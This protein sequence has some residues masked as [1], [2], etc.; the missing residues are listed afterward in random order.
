M[1]NTAF[2]HMLGYESLDDL[3]PATLKNLCFDP[4]QAIDFINTI[5]QDGTKGID[6]RLKR[7]DGSLLWGF[8]T[9]RPG[10]D[11][12][13]QATYFDCTIED[14]TDRRQA[15]K[16]REAMYLISQAA[17]TA[18]NLEDLLKLVHKII[19]DLMPANNF[20]LALFDAEHNTVSFPYY[21]DE[22][23]TPP[24]I[25]EFGKGLTDYVIRTG[26][27]LLVSPELYRKMV[28]AGEIAV[29][30]TPAV[31]WLGVPLKIA[32]NQAIGALVVQT[33][34]EGIRYTEYDKEVLAFVSSQAAMAIERKRTEDALRSSEA[35][36]RGLLDAVP[37]MII[38]LDQDGTFLDYRFPETVQN[39]ISTP[40]LGK[41]YLKSSP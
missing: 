14:I 4:M 20:Y 34:N 30:G 1:S 27:P 7:K 15:E 26:Q 9:A 31:D 25:Q 19:G 5:Q 10:L 18:Q 40:L 37:D 11:E 3:N 24:S 6:V 22:F 8:V 39:F 38:M 29:V 12:K 16:V 33:Y 2:I 41:N 28:E 32:E 13:G 35:R 23:D 21:V 36:Q 17:N